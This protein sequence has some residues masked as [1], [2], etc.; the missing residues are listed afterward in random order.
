MISA[1]QL[2]AR[3]D[4]RLTVGERGE[5]V[6]WMRVMVGIMMRLVQWMRLKIIIILQLM[7]FR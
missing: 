5:L 4:G 6:I 1:G 2:L 3:R 7:T